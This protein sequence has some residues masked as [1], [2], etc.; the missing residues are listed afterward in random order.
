VFYLISWEEKPGWF[1]LETIS[2]RSNPD[3]APRMGPPGEMNLTRMAVAWPKSAH[4][5]VHLRKSH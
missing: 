3:G 5:A 2:R 4:E 1:F